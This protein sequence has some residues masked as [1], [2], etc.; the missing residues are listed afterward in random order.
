MTQGS[1]GTTYQSTVTYVCNEGYETS[2]STTLT[3]QAD[4][5]WSASTGPDCTGMFEFEDN[6]KHKV[7]NKKSK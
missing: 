3:C 1:T 4:R 2:G 6:K 5:Q 7:R